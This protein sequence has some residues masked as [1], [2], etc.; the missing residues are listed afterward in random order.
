MNPFRQTLQHTSDEA[1]MQAIAKREE[2][3]FAELY[4][5]YGP[6][7]YSFFMRMLWED[8]AKGE[9]FT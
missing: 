7:M 2:R 6:R 4:D 3:A 8:A 9:D 5:R 1:L